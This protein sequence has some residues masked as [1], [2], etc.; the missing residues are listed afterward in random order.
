M[1][2]LHRGADV[3][4]GL[5]QAAKIKTDAELDYGVTE[6]GWGT[7]TSSW[8]VITE[9]STVLK[10]RCWERWSLL[11][12]RSWETTDVCTFDHRTGFGSRESSSSENQLLTIYDLDNKFIAYSAP[13]E[14]VI[15]VV[16]E[17][18]L[19]YIL[20]RDGKMFVLQEKD[21]QTKLEV[22]STDCPKGNNVDKVA[23]LLPLWFLRCCL[24]RTCL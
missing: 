17:W 6:S 9:N 16:A 7:F 22:S 13:F 10:E 15:D 3:R 8:G 19:F 20:T 5:C 12:L 4:H 2:R 23:S 21:T 1:R 11:D 18:G 24:R 14:D